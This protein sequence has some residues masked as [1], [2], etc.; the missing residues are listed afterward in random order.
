MVLAVSL[1][2]AA[3]CGGGGVKD[4]TPVGSSTVTVT[5]SGGSVSQS[6][7]IAAVVQK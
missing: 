2:F 6:V 1:A 3:G 7:T 5:A 4:Q